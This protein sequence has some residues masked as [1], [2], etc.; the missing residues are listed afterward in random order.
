MNDAVVISIAQHCPKLETLIL[1]RTS[2]ITYA[3]LIALSERGL[4]LKELDIPYVPNIPTADIAGRCS[5]A[6]SCIRHLDTDNL[7]EN[8][9]DANILIPYLTGLTSVDLDYY[10]NVYILLLTRHCHKLIC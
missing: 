3:S 1:D 2:M 10:D 9:Q 4:P 5:H 6:L 7:Y 8:G